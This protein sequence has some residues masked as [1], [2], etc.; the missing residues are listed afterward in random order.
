MLTLLLYQFY[1]N[2]IGLLFV[3]TGHANFYLIDVQY[4]QEVIFNFEK[5]S[6]GQ[7]H[8]PSGSNHLIQ[9]FPSKISDSY[10]NGEE[11]FTPTTFQFY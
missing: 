2:V 7:N 8:S 6:N 9:K 11:G 1:F 3:Y 10:T 4:L 5:G